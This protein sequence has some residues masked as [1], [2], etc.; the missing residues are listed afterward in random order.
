MVEG[1]LLINDLGGKEPTK[2]GL[3]IEIK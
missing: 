1:L 3:P 2:K